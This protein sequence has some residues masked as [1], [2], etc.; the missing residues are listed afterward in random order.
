MLATR[1]GVGPGLVHYHFA[2]L[3]A[4]LT[5][6]AL[7]V[8][9]GL[10]DELT[11]LLDQVRSPE[12]GLELIVGGLGGHDPQDPTS[13][14]FSEAYL[15]ATRDA[16]LR[17]AIGEL[18]VEFRRPLALWLAEHDVPEPEATAAVLAAALDGIMLHRALSPGLTAEDITRVLRRLLLAPD[19]R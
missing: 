17:H 14:L 8:M 12:E 1:A 16:E 3:Q 10:A 5:E 15:A 9:R 19:P 11:A 6:A 7:G 2:S 13:R 4:L 18:I